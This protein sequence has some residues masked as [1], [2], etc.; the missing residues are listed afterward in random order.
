MYTQ[1]FSGRPVQ[2][3]LDAYDWWKIAEPGV[4]QI[5]D[6]LPCLHPSAWRRNEDNYADGYGNL[7]Q[8]MLK[9]RKEDQSCIAPT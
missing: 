9:A 4:A 8:A 5:K 2:S 6:V 7:I 3:W 1:A